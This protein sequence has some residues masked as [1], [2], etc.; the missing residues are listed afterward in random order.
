MSW[1]H[2]R[3]IEA[4]EARLEEEY[5]AAGM[6]KEQIEA[7][8]AFDREVQRSNR[9]FYRHNQ[10][11]SPRGEA[12]DNAEPREDGREFRLR[13]RMGWLEEIESPALAECLREADPEL[14]EILTLWVF[15]GWNQREVARLLCCS[16]QNVTEILRNFRARLRSRMAQG[17]EA[18]D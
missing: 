13:D 11:L 6:T 1:Y 3:N 9:R 10:R 7:I 18:K 2:N 5:R 16:R 4:E 17:G 14:L 12:E 15:E 8:R